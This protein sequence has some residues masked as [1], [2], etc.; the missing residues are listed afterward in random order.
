MPGSASLCVSSL[1]V[2]LFWDAL[3]CGSIGETPPCCHWSQ[4]LA[5]MPWVTLPTCNRWWVGCLDLYFATCV[6]SFPFL[7]LIFEVWIY[8]FISSQCVGDLGSWHQNWKWKRGARDLLSCLT[9][10]DFLWGSWVHL[11]ID[12][13][14][15]VCI[16]SWKQIK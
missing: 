6:F 1:P 8:L 11:G 7:L 4:S 15:F 12:L 16:C 10:C 3:V 2:L 9:C 14:I 13:F 5:S